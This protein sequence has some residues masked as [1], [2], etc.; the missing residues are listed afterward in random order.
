MYHDT[1]DALARA[2]VAKSGFMRRHPV[3]YFVAAMLAG[4]YVGFGIVLI[5]SV[6]APFAH[7]SSPAVKILMGVSFGIALTLVIVAGAE[8]FT[9]LTMVMV[10]GIMRRAT[11][12][13]DLGRI[14]GL[15]YA[16][17]LAGALILSLMVANAGM[18]DNAAFR[19]FV[20]KAAS[21]KMQAPWDEL[22]AR[23]I[24]CNMLVCLAIWMCMRLKEDIARMIAIFWCLFAF[25]AS[26]Y[27]HSIANMT[28]LSIPLMGWYDPAVVSWAGY[29]RNLAIVTAGNI[30]G[31]GICV[32][33][34]YGFISL[35][36]QRTAAVEGS[37]TGQ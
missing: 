37:T 24:L 18:L 11:R 10:V 22:F 3:R 13:H 35:T 21:A 30:I 20:S 14:W 8:L 31:G 25:V 34:A 29:A 27:E 7:A 33:A 19:Q 17:N 23:A 6:G 15:S 26:G 16:G 36:P 4:V 9:G 12:L 2:A 1:I 28:L 5:F 32:G